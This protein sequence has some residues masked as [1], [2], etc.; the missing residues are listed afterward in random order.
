MARQP[1]VFAV[2][3]AVGWAL[4][5]HGARA[6]SHGVTVRPAGGELFEVE[7]RQIATASFRVTN[8]SA[9]T[10]QFVAQILLPSDWRLI[11][12]EFPFDLEPGRSEVR[13][14]S[15]FVPRAT[16]AGRYS[17]TCL[18]EDRT[19]PAVA[20]R[21]AVTV[22]VLPV[23]AL[24]AKLL[25]VPQV[26]IAGEDYKASF[27]V[28]DQGNVPA[29]LLFSV[30][31]G[32]GLPAA[33][34]PPSCLLQPGQSKVVTVTVKTNREL[35]Q[36]TKH[37]LRFLATAPELKKG[38]RVT[39]A[40]CVEVVPRVTAA[41]DPYYRLPTQLTFRSV[42]TDAGRR[43][44][45]LQAEWSGRG[46]LDEEKRHEIDF[47]FRGP[48]LS[49][50]SVYGLRD[51]YR[52][53]YKTDGLA[54]HLGDRNYA[55]TPLT[56]QSLYGRGAEMA[57]QLDG[58]ATVGGYC[59]QSRWLDPQ[60]R[61][62]AAYL[63]FPVADRHDLQISY[64]RRSLLERP[65]HDLAPR[66]REGD[67][68]SL[69]SRSSP[70]DGLDLDLEYAAGDSDSPGR[71]GLDSALRAEALG[72]LGPASYQ[73]KFIRA[74]PDFPGYY[75]DMQFVSA[76]IASPLVGPLG[77]HADYRNQKDNLER[78]PH[79][80][81]APLD[82]YRRF[83]LDWRS[84]T[85]TTL[86][87][88][89]QHRA[90]EDLLPAPKFDE[91]EKTVGL[92]LSQS[93]HRLTLSL[94]AESGRIYDHLRGESAPLRQYR[95][96]VFCTPTRSQTY[97]AY[98][99]TRDGGCLGSDKSRNL[100]AG[101]TGSWRFDSRTALTLDLH[102]SEYQRLASGCRDVLE[103]RF[104]RTL[105]NKATFGLKARHT[106]STS[107]IHGLSGRKETTV[108]LEYSIPIGI[109]LGRRK[110]VGGLNGRVFD[111]ETG[112]GIPNAVL[113]LNGAAAV[114]DA[115]GRYVFPAIRPGQYYLG[116]DAGR[117]GVGKV[118]CRR[119]PISV[120]VVGGRD[121][122]V[123]IPFARGA[124]LTGK[125][126]LYRPRGVAAPFT[127]DGSKRPTPPS[128][129]AEAG[130]IPNVMI[131]LV[132]GPDILRGV[133]D[134]QG[135][136]TFAACPPGPWT[137]RV[138]APDLPEHHVAEPA[139][140]QVSLSPSEATTVLIRVLPQSRPVRIIQDGGTL[141]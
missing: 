80:K 106:S 109:A 57:V 139:T 32:Q 50:R 123:D 118:P 30:Y 94:A 51:E 55:L 91:E 64:L 5:A 67:I 103:L 53:S 127:A 40:S 45:G 89:Y 137:V 104:A 136:F 20:D 129:L 71:R 49:G 34:D 141:R 17:I 84:R 18:V 9:R 112:R 128:D 119:V 24:G 97:S 7:P 114:T 69:R 63:R 65:P 35:Q 79:L 78:D 99:A 44:G 126:I 134:T 3:V 113:R 116:V 2:M 122:T 76:S 46:F 27:L 26:V 83:G 96:S 6:E 22:V 124:R 73:V 58:G 29:K 11:T 110:S 135:G 13:L 68:L 75:S 88:D 47:L 90:R 100:T 8:Q 62:T 36:R 93:I 42:Y 54:L 87:M 28:V 31:S 12:T 4:G 60:E 125:V 15:F 117:T 70:L 101:F 132:S 41:E 19:A 37:V 105:A 107:S 23:E 115:D 130:G 43:T 120:T 98:V 10:R 92:T 138:H 140:L 111:Q 85:G 86:S 25:D 66:A 21:Y 133:T 81:S 56:E 82:R 38:G 33:I 39:V 131:E 77:F 74:G 102:R 121:C 1:L 14:V 59:A 95:A 61:Q 72:R 16:L 108:M 48:D 52:V